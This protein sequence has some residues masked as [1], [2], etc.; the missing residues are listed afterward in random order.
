MNA[1]ADRVKFAVSVAEM[2]VIYILP[3][4]G[5]LYFFSRLFAL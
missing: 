4:L 5:G 2:M 1:G 3:Q